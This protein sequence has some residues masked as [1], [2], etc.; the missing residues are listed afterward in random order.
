M[1]IGLVASLATPT[2]DRP[3]A[4]ALPVRETFH[5]ASGP[6]GA[7]SV[8]GDSVLLGSVLYSP[9]IG[10]ALA[11]RGWGPVRVRAG[12]SY[13]TGAFP[14]Q[15]TARASYWI[16]AWR[17]QGWDAPN[18]VVNLGTND[19]GFCTTSLACARDAIVHV[20]DT[21]GPGHRIWWPKITRGP[22][23]RHWAANWNLALD[24]I[25]AE[26]P[27]FVTWDWPTVMAT[28]G[29]ASNDGIHLSPEGYRRRSTL[30]ATEITN[31]LARAT[32]TGA[33]APL[34]APS[35]PPSDV[36][37]VGPVRVLDTRTDPPGRMA[38]GTS[39]A[40]D[41]S[42]SIPA[43]STAVAVYVAATGATD[44][45][46]LTAFECGRD[47]P[48]A[49]AANYPAGGTRGAVTITPVSE[50]G[51]FC[52]FSRADTDVVVD[53]QAAFVPLGGATDGLR[54][55]PLATPRRLLDTRIT[56]RR[57]M[58]E[59]PVP[60]GADM[61]AV[62]IAA[63]DGASRG[64]LVAYPCTSDVPTIAT[65]NHGPREVIAGTAFV[66]VG[67][68]GTICVSA[69]S[70]VDLTV[71]LTGTFSDDGDLV[72]R[73]APP[74]RTIDTR[75]ATGGWAPIHGNG[76]TIDA[77]VAPAQARA[78][79]GTLTIVRPASA[80]HLRS[81]GCGALPGTANVNGAAGDVTANSVTTGLGDGGRLC[82]YAR[83]T[84]STVFD[85]TGWWIPLP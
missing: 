50:R 57:P 25:A 21:I 17:R 48:L 33:E 6:N 4:A 2:T 70:A 78:V 55:T 43:G 75:D 22:E 62:S 11:E 15:P 13:S 36:V 31:V 8:I 26:R 46:Y 79:S 72:F 18:V 28:P 45:G 67:A 12:G 58:I 23:H 82:V 61:V 77:R 60:P 34:P 73:P 19:S 54:F 47:R 40:V 52:L 81:W 27:E 49:S 41:V 5:A 30:M 14:V 35:A 42:D 63:I 59:I 9:T 64:H 66:P 74:T 83:S 53:L 20:L 16:E 39:V 7:I 29:F 65:V 10:Q 37:P 1:T 69:K 80:G 71:D 85:T 44:P 38:A 51:I 68:D 76:Q 3:V 56:G 32:R 84:T 24:Q